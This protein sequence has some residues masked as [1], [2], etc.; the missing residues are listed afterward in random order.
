M[1]CVLHGLEV[2]PGDGC[3][4]IWNIEARTHIGELHTTEHH[5]YSAWYLLP[6]TD[7]HMESCGEYVSLCEAVRTVGER[8]FQAASAWHRKRSAA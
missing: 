7:D 4:Q 2:R 3:L 1:S 6:G 8:R 5:L